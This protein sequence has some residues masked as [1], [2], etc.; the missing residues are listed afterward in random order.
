MDHCLYYQAHV[1]RKYCWFLVGILR[2][3]E[4]MTFDRT[5]DKENSI[6]EF[7]VPKLMKRHFE[8]LLAFFMK[9]KIIFWYTQMPNRLLKDNTCL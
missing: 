5:I 8:E 9:E 3:F 6:F 1:Q 7:Y 2:S 4:N